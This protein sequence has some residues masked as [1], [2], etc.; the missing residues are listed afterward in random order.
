M[1]SEITKEAYRA[2]LNNSRTAN[3]LLIID[4]EKN[5]LFKK[6]VYKANGVILIEIL[7]YTSKVTQYYVQDINA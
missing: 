6:E 5:E 2:I 1:N 7:N 4:F 3:E